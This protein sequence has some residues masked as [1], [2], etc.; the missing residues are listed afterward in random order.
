MS[1]SVLN[2]SIRP[3][4]RSLTR[5][6][7]MRSV[8]ANSA[9][10]R[11]LDA[12]S[13]WTLIIRSAR[14]SRCSASPGANPRSRKTLPVDRVILSFIFNLPCRET[15]G[16]SFQDQRT[17]PISRE[18]SFPFGSFSRPFLE[19]MQN[20]NTL[21]ELCHVENSMLK[22]SVDADFLNTGTH[23]SHRFPI[24]RFKPLLDT[25]QLV[26]GDTACVLRESPKV[27]SRRTEPNQRLVRHGTICGY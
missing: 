16:A 14:T 23:G 24:V 8:F 26:T 22:A 21:H 19:G 9:C 27:A 15:F 13:F 18:I 4:R 17:K 3:R 25:T 12:I 2:R 1:A 5:G 20:V 11:R 7:V 10:V 6:W